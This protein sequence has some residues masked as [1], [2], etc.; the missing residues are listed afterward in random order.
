MSSLGHKVTK[1][2]RGDCILVGSMKTLRNISIFFQKKSTIIFNAAQNLKE[3][4]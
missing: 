2:P 4:I 3:I 1:T